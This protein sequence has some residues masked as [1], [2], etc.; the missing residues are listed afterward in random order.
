MPVTKRSIPS[1]QT[2]QWNTAKAPLSDLLQLAFE[3]AF[4]TIPLQRFAAKKRY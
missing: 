4:P 1:S 3:S 2:W